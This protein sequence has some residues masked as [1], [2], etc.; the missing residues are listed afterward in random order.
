[1]I[2]IV[3]PVF[4]GNNSARSN[5]RKRDGLGTVGFD[6]NGYLAFFKKLSPELIYD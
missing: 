6:S 1:M 3:V 4:E 5:E 2:L